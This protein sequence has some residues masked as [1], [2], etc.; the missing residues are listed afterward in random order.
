MTVPT[1][2]NADADSAVWSGFAAA[3]TGVGATTGVGAKAT[4]GTGADATGEIGADTT[5][6]P[7][8]GHHQVAASAT[9]STVT[10]HKGQRV[11]FVTKGCMPV[12]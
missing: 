4:T 9:M 10:D 2:L 6:L 1:S 11:R 8:D 3:G 7:D 12:D 5:A